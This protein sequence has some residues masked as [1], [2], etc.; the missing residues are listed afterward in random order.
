MS[1][2]N[3]DRPSPRIP[4][5]MDKV[6]VPLWMLLLAAACKVVWLAVRW[7]FRHR[8]AVVVV[9]GLLLFTHRFGMVGLG[10]LLGGL[11]VVVLAWARLHPRSL[12]WL[13][14][15]VLGR[16]R[17]AFVYRW[18][19]QSAMV[20]TDLAIRMPASTGD[21]V[22]FDEVFPRIRTIRSTRAVDV[23]RVELLPGQT[24]QKW[25][26][27]AEALRH[28]FRARRCQVHAETFRFVRLHF[29][30]CDPLTPPTAT[31]S[32]D[33]GE[34]FVP[35]RGLPSLARQRSQDAATPHP[36]GSGGRPPGQHRGCWEGARRATTMRN[37]R[38]ETRG[39]EPRTPALQRQCSAN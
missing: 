8:V 32:C 6:R 34:G 36:G 14:C 25:A 35:A 16:A 12:A 19:W 10:A 21:Q 30:R 29:H 9:V 26:E 39:F 33:G 17:L 4:T 24:P 7:G 5:R 28:I 27:Q 2:I 18:R 11:A 1:R 38:V 13:G 15:W 37:Q 31:R 22:T 3:G 20:H 23:L